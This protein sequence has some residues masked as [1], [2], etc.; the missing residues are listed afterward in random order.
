MDTGMLDGAAIQKMMNSS[1]PTVSAVLLKADGTVEEVKYDTTPKANEISKFL[2]GAPTIV[3]Q[4]DQIGGVVV[5]KKREVTDEDEKNHHLLRFPLHQELIKGHLF[6][7]RMDENANAVDFSKAEYEEFAANSVEDADLIANWELDRLKSKD[8]AET[9]D[10]PKGEELVSVLQA[11]LGDLS[12]EQR[13]EILEKAKKEME[14]ETGDAPDEKEFDQLF[15]ELSDPA[16]RDGNDSNGNPVDEAEA[17][18]EMLRQTAKS[19]FVRQSGGVEPTE[20]QLQAVMDRLQALIGGGEED[21]DEEF[22]PEDGDE[23]E[24]EDDKAPEEQEDSN[25]EAGSPCVGA[26]KK[27]PLS[28]NEPN[29]KKQKVDDDV[30]VV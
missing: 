13:S 21:D 14:A 22:V 25:G 17:M 24:D 18:Q 19:A 9:T 1:G 7:V 30:E 28:P 6:C 5:C 26:A 23:N 8:E 16:A 29:A 20:E 12:Q 27:H 11:C 15:N 3:G 2:G 4:W 10:M